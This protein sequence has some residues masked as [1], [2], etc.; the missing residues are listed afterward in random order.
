MTPLG[1]AA[2]ALALSAG[3]GW[4]AR[5]LFTVVTVDGISMT[6]ALNPGDRLLVGPLWRPP[7]RGEVVTLRPP[8]PLPAGHAHPW[9]VKRVAAVAGDAVPG[10]VARSQP[11]LAG[12]RVPSGQVIVLGDHPASVDSKAWGLLPAGALGG[13]VIRRLAPRG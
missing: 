10:A 3:L 6:P 13:R 12:Q 8:Q 2:A 7:R 4:A 5:R 9:M 11:A 1:T